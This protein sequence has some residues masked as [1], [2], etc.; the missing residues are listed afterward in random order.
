MKNDD[1]SNTK[2]TRPYQDPVNADDVKEI[3]KRAFGPTVKILNH[4]VRIFSEEKLGFMGSYRHLVV[5]IQRPG[6]TERDLATFFLKA[7]PHDIEEQALLIQESNAFYK[8]I[9]FYKRIMPDLMSSVKDKAW[10]AQC[11]LIKDDVMAFE[12][13][14]TRNFV[15]KDKHLDAPALKAALTGLAKLHA[16]P[17]LAEKRLGKTFLELYPELFKESLFVREGRFYDWFRTSVDVIVAVAKQLRVDH[18]CVG[19][20]CD[21]VYKMVLPSTKW[22][23]VICHVDVKSYNFFFDDSVEPVPRCVLRRSTWRSCSI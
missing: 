17:I 12:D 2:R 22:Q 5:T 3:I 14:K 4:H 8:E 1:K 20:V 13:L 21:K 19:K 7:I 11:Y 15:L 16:S 10:I 6:T 9:N 18:E 23:N